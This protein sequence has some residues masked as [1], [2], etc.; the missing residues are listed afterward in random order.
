MMVVCSD[1]YLLKTIE[2]AL[3]FFKFYNH[4]LGMVLQEK[5][6]YVVVDVSQTS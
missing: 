4:L 1:K 2:R 3:C 6:F 5:D